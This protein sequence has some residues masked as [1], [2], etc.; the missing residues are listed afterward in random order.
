MKKFTNAAGSVVAESLA[1][2]VGA[3][4]D[5]VVFGGEGK[6][7]RRLHLVPGKVAVISGGG[8]GHEPMHAGFVGRGMLDAACTGHVFT[9]P[10][11][12]QIAAAIAGTDTGAGCLLV[13]KNYDGDVMNFE[14][15]AEMAAGRHRIETVIVG[16]DVSPGGS[17][18]S[19]GR[20]GLAGTL[21]VEKLLGAAAEAGADVAALKTAGDALGGRIR[22]M[23]VAWRGVALPETRRETFSLD[24]E[25]MEVGIGIHGEPGRQRAAF[26]TADAI[27]E[28]MTAAILADLPQADRERALL[29]VNGL[30]G[31]PPSD[32]YL[33]QHLARRR[34][35][36]AGATVARTLTGTFA[37]SL[38]MAG[39]S[40][41]VCLLSEAELALWD[42]PV[43]TGALRW[44]A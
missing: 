24:E 26:A 36:A 10:T 42:A 8:G 33:A 12:D 15:A 21:I 1:G 34:V 20:R 43:A 35:E 32:L 23:G 44:R 5:L 25:E 40:L 28:R 31:T 2:F 14:M 4:P 37:T 41:T 13:V 27:V 3:H 17:A 38:D 11:P 6:F 19:H 22:T 16:D 18:R 9:S 29:I 30:G 39:L 7:V